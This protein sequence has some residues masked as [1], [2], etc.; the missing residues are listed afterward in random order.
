[1]AGPQRNAPGRPGRPLTQL[2]MVAGGLTLMESDANNEADDVA[3][4]TVSSIL[5][6]FGQSGLYNRDER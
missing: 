5:I 2:T 4:I 1:L 3:M 6:G